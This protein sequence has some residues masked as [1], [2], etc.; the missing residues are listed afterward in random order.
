[1]RASLSPRSI[2]AL[3]IEAA[4]RACY[5]SAIIKRACYCSHLLAAL[6]I[7]THTDPTDLTDL[8]SHADIAEIRRKFFNKNQENPFVLVE[9]TPLMSSLCSFP[10]KRA[11]R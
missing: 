5:R 6:N 7:I 3:N 11:F 4:L 1:M 10:C 8:L 9:A 2:A